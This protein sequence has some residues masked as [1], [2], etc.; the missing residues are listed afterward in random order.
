MKLY[1]EVINSTQYM[2]KMCPKYIQIIYFLLK[3]RDKTFCIKQIQI[4]E[5]EIKNNLESY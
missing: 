5:M 2:K 1:Y 3:I 4:S